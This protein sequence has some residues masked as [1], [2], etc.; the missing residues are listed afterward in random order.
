M[1]ASAII[2]RRQYVPMLGVTSAI[3]TASLLLP[4]QAAAQPMRAIDTPYYL[5]KTNVSDDDA[6]EAVLRV[7]AMFE[8]YGR[9]TSGFA[10]AV[11]QKMPFELHRDYDEYLRST[12][13]PGTAGV[14]TGHRLV[15]SFQD[16]K[17]EATWHTVQ[18]EGF[19]QFVDLAMG[20]DAIPIWA[21]EGL[22]EYFG[23]GIWTGD[24]FVTGIIPPKRLERIQG[25]LKNEGFRPLLELMNVSHQQWNMEGSVRNYDQAWVLV[26]FLAHGKGGRYADRFGEF[27]RQARGAGDWQKLWAAKLDGNVG[28]LERECK[29]WWLGL[30]ENPTRDQYVSATCATLTSFYARACA[31]RQSFERVE[32]FFA[33]SRDRTLKCKPNSWLPP[34]LLENSLEQAPR[35]GK[36]RLEKRGAWRLMVCERPGGAK[37]EGSFKLGTGG[38]VKDVTVRQTGG[39]AVTRSSDKPPTSRPAKGKASENRTPARRGGA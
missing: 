31:E 26:H 10:G 15:A 32:D 24:G 11:N 35:C 22:A 12:D 14:Y 16:G 19:H 33:A 36:W 20:R 9:R 6:R 39:D 34:A 7:T 3:L 8:E 37:W 4:A 28:A 21:N 5:I 38:A 30:S 18:H 13:A 1:Q 27:L 29:E 25:L 2:K 17:S 23:E